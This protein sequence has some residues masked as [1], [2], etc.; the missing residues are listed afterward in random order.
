MEQLKAKSKEKGAEIGKKVVLPSSFQGSARNMRQRFHDAMAMV[1]RMGKPDLFI[2]FTCNPNW[3]SIKRNLLPGQQPSDRPD[4]VV[5]VFKLALEELLRD[6]ID[7]RLFG[8]VLGW[9]YTI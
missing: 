4:I 6:I 3:E 2:T 9:T 8:R 1:I 7:R 5:R